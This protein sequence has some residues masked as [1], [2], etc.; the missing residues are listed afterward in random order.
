M[1]IAHLALVIAAVFTGAAVY[2]NVAEQ[3]AR[4]LLD[5]KSLLAEW[6]VSYRR[7]FMMQASLAALGTLLG[8]IA[9]VDLGDQLLL[10]GA[11]ALF[12]NW[13]LTIFLIMPSNNALMATAPDD[14]SAETRRLIERWGRLHAVRSVLGAFATIIFL[15]ALHR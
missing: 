6:K 10:V 3:P 1:L 9:Y 12:A 4:L 15:W 11:L 13:P 8:L 2:I 14:A 5:D 7:G